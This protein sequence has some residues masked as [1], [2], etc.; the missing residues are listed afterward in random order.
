[1]KKIYKNPSLLL[2]LF[3]LLLYLFISI[4]LCINMSGNIFNYIAAIIPFA[5][6]IIFILLSFKSNIVGGIFLSIEGALIIYLM[7]RYFV[8]CKVILSIILFA[9]PILIYGLFLI[10]CTIFDYKLKNTPFKNTYRF[11]S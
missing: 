1:M 10:S 8:F 9:L 6:T 7:L 3:S 5:A 4:I 2:S 11:F